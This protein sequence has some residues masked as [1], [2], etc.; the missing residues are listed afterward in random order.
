MTGFP[1]EAE[2]FGGI[3]VVRFSTG[4]RSRIVFRG[5]CVGIGRDGGSGV[6]LTSRAQRRKR[7]ECGS[8]THVRNA[9]TG[10]LVS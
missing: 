2:R 10:G 5:D 8:K 3:A 4:V 1:S 6:L 9:I 7:E